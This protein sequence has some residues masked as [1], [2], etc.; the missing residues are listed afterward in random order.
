MK[1]FIYCLIFVIGFFAILNP[2]FAVDAEG[3]SDFVAVDA[4]IPNAVHIIIVVLQIAI[5]VLLV[6]F[7]TID[8]LKAVTSSKEDEIKKGRTTFIQR[9]IA[10]VIVFF[11]VAIVKLIV[12]FAGGNDSPDI[13]KCANCFLNGVDAKGTCK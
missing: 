4:K 12:S 10:A 8:F 9:V 6:I 7:G 13:I 3:C 11:I 1:K 5:P 2:V